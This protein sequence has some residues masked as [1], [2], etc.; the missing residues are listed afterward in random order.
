MS[1]LSRRLVYLGFAIA[2]FVAG[3]SIQRLWLPR[4]SPTPA[5]QVEG[6]RYA[7]ETPVSLIPDEQNGGRRCLA[8]TL[9]YPD[10][11]TFKTNGEVES[12]VVD[13]YCAK[14][15]GQLEHAV[16]NDDLGAVRNALAL[17]A[18]PN[19]PGEF[20]WLNYPLT[21]ASKYGSFALVKLL[22]DNGAEVDGQK[23]A[24]VGCGTP[25]L[26]AT[27]RN[28]VEM[29]RLLLE[30]GARTDYVEPLSDR[31][32]HSYAVSNRNQEMIELLEKARLR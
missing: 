9:Y 31:T 14:L 6:V 20:Y 22:L 12:G 13:R 23:A 29:V 15:Q 2:T 1:C 28:N 19:S 30:R 10:A 18:D 26:W 7:P 21:T 5:Q 25:L 11:A 3:V 17:G 27:Q 4:S 8:H 24:C 32:A 16:A